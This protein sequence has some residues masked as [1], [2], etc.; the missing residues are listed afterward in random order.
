MQNF[1]ILMVLSSLVLLRDLARIVRWDRLGNFRQQLFVL[2]GIN[3]WMAVQFQWLGAA[4]PLFWCCR[5]IP[6]LWLPVEIA[7]QMQRKGSKALSALLN[8]PELEEVLS[9]SAFEEST[10][11]PRKAGIRSNKSDLKDK[12]SSSWLA[13]WENRCP[14]SGSSPADRPIV[15]CVAGSVGSVASFRQSW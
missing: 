8:L 5:F 6:I 1:S 2:G 14:R 10:K 7:V 9:F 15:A 13:S 11:G 3:I 12:D 4:Q